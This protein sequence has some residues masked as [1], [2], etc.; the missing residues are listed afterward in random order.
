M[1]ERPPREMY[2]R[3]VFSTPRAAEFLEIEA[4]QAQTGQYRDA[5]GDVV[6]K[7]VIDNALD[8]CEFAGVTPKIEVRLDDADYTWVGDNG[9]GVAPELV[10]RILDFSTLT[11]D[12]AVYRSP[13]RGAQ[14]NALKTVV[15]I[16]AA[17][18]IAEPVV[19]EACGVRHE[20]AVSIDPGGNVVVV[21]ERAAIGQTTGTRIGVPIVPNEDWVRRFVMFNP[22]AFVI[23]HGQ[24]GDSD[25]AD[26][27]R[28]TVNSGW[29]KPLPTD[30]TSPHW[31]DEAAMR[32]LVFAHIGARRNGSPDVP[33]GTFIRQFAGLSSPSKAKLVAAA[34]PGISHLSDLEA[35]SDLIAVLLTAM[36]SEAAVPK[37]AVLG[38]I[39]E[40]HHRAYLDKWFGVRQFWFKRKALLDGRGVPWLV[41]VAVATTVD[42]GDVFYGT[43]YSPTFSDP[44]AGWRIPGHE[45]MTSGAD[46]FLSEADAFP[47]ESND[48]H[49]A[50]VMHI[51]CPALDFLDKGKTRLAVPPPEAGVEIVKALQAATKALFKE[52]KRRER[53]TRQ[54]IDCIIAFEREERYSLK[55]AVSKVIIQAAEQA[56]GGLRFSVRTLYYQVRPL[57]QPYT[58][59]ELGYEYFS[60]TLVPDYE[61][62]HGD[63][64]GMYREPRGHLHEPHSDVSV[65]LGTIEIETYVPTDW[66]FDK[67]LYVEKEGLWPTI[68]DS[69]LAE[70]FDMAVIVGQGYAVE[71]CRSFLESLDP[72]RYRI[73]TLTDADWSG[74][75]IAITLGEETRRMPGYSV[76]VTNLGLT[77]A[78]AKRARLP[79]E[80]V[81]RRNE[82]PY[83]VLVRLDEDEREWFVGTPASSTTWSCTRVE[84]NAF[85]GPDLIAYIEAGLEAAG[86][87][88][89]L[90]PPAEVIAD[91]AAEHHEMRARDEIEAHIR[92]LLNSEALVH[93]LVAATRDDA[94]VPVDDVETALADNP[95]ISWRRTTTDQVDEQLGNTLTTQA[96]ELVRKALDGWHAH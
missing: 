39:P 81:I 15:G 3:R 88:A 82:I 84:L 85:T 64:K 92:R 21:H 53:G 94:E 58:D 10:E 36:K 19:I 40:E 12:K 9:P 78:D 26:S 44:L 4:L 17:L 60:Q 7:E 28:P 90:I 46:G 83:R 93:K 91:H 2:H 16:P 89:K 86:A 66:T 25:N 80:N 31:Y 47:G 29:C 77:V 37:P 34:V 49:R 96:E 30:R 65:P 41:E 75:N 52:R 48:K 43:N 8:A 42:E 5:F 22:H 70:R 55:H 61:R 71:A 6:V 20:I 76:E 13:T 62:E 11:S 1:P 45:D 50:C 57:I 59:K 56:S 79:T 69:K 35:G 18:G 33:L 74:Y 73:F 14:G 32:R 27:Y 24:S 72:G 67:I 38:R 68:Q 95:P 23:D 51:V 63:L 87:A 54:R